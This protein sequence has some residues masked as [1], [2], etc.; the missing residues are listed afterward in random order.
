MASGS[1]ARVPAHAWL[2]AQ[3][4]AV[5]LMSSSP[6][7]MLEACA[8]GQGIA[9]LPEG[10]ADGRVQ[11]LDLPVPD[12]TPVWLLADRDEASHPRIAPFLRWARAYFRKERQPA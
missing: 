4:G 12:A 5:A 2:A 8:R 10:L 7:A 3:G 11:R 9:L 6:L 1:L